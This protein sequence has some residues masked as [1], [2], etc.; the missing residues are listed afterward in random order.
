MLSHLRFHRR[1][2][3]NPTSP[4]RE[5]AP[6][7]EAAAQREQPQPARDVSPRPDARPRSPNSSQLPPT[8]PPIVRVAST[9]SDLLFSP[10]HDTP[11]LPPSHDARQPPSRPAYDDGNKGGFI[12]GVALRNYRRAAQDPRPPDTGT[13]AM[14]VQLPENQLSRAKAPP[15]PIITGLTAR[16]A[17]PGN[18]QTKSSWFSTPTDLQGPGA[19]GKR[20]TAPRLASEPTPGPPPEP[21][22]GRKGLPF[23]KNPMSSLLMR[24]KTGQTVVEAHPPALSY[25]PRIK[26]TRVHDFS[27]PRPK[28]TLSL[29]SPD[30]VSAPRQETV[31]PVVRPADHGDPAAPP[32]AGETTEYSPVETARD[33]LYGAGQGENGDTQLE[34]EPTRLSSGTILPDQPMSPEPPNDEAATSLHTSSSAASRDT[35]IAPLP[36]TASASVRTTASR[37]LSV[38]EASR[39]DSVAS[40]IPRHMKSTSSRFSFD[41]IGAAKQEKLLEERHRQREQEKKSSDDPAEADA[42]FNDFDDDFDYDAMMDDDGLEERIPGVNAD[43]EYEEYEEDQEADFDPD[44]DQENF[45]G[46]EFQRSEPASSLASPHTPGMLAT[47]RDTAGKVIEAAQMAAASGKFRRSSS[48]EGLAG[49]ADAPPADLAQDDDAEINRYLDD[50]GNDNAEINGYLDDYGNDDAEINGYLDD[51]GNDDFGNDFDDF[52]FDDEAIIAEANA[53]ALAYDSDGFYGQEFGFY[54]SAPAPQHP[55]NNH[56]HQ[57]PTTQPSA[58]VLTTENLFQYANGGYF[59][60]ASAGIDRSA[61]GRVCR[62]PNLTPITERSEYSN[63]NSVMSFTLPPAIGDNGGRNSASLTSPGLA[64]LALLPDDTDSMSLSALMKL[65]SKAWGGSQASLVSSREGSPRSERAAGP[66]GVPPPPLDGGGSPYGTVPAHLAGH[67]RVNSGL[68][69]WSSFSADEAAAE[70]G[71]SGAASPAAAMAMPPRPGSAGAVVNGGSAG[72]N[73]VVVSPLPQ[74]PHSLFLPPLPPPLPVPSP[75]GGQQQQMGGSACSPVLEG[76]EADPEAAAVV[77]GFALAPALPLR[78]RSSIEVVPGEVAEGGAVPQARRLGGGHRHKGSADSISYMKDGGGN[79]WNSFGVPSF[80]STRC[81]GCDHP[82]PRYTGGYGSVRSNLGTLL[83]NAKYI[84]CDVCA[85][86]SEGILKFL[87]DKSCGVTREDVDELRVDFNLASSR[88][89]LEA[90]LLLDTP[91]KL[92]FFASESTPWISETLPDLPG[93]NESHTACNSFPAAPLPSRVLDVAAPGESGV[94]LY[95]SEGETAPYTA[96]S[97]CW[98]HKP[99]LRTLSGSLDDHKS[100]I[101]WARLPLSFQDAI[102]FTRQLGIRYLWID[103]LC[104]IQDD[105]HD[106]CHEAAKMG[107]VYQNADLVISAAK[108]SGAY[109]GMYAELP[110]K[111][112]IHTIQYTPGRDDDGD[113]DDDFS[114]SE[115]EEVNTTADK[116]NKPPPE[117]IHIRL[118]LS[119]THRLLSPYHAPTSSLPIFTRGWI[120]QERLLSPRILHFGPEELSFECFESSTCQC[121]LCWRRLVE[122]YSRLRLT[123]G[124]DVFPAVS[125]MARQMQSVRG[126]GTRYVAGLWED[127][128]VWGDLLWHVQLPPSSSSPSTEGETLVAGAGLDGDGAAAR[129]WG[130]KEVCR[131]AGWRAP[132]WSWASVCAPVEFVNGDEGL[133]PECE[134]VE[135]ACEPAG[136]DLLGELVEGGSWLVLK[137]RLVPALLRFND[138]EEPEPWN[139][140]DLD[141]LDGGH[142]KNLWVDDD[143]QGLVATEG[144]QPRVYCLLVG[145]KLPRKELLFLVLA[146][147]PEDEEKAPRDQGPHEDRHLYRRIGMMEIFGGPASP[148]F[149]GWVHNLLGKGEDAVVK[150]V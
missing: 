81:R 80:G 35:Q 43:Y 55:P 130:A 139:L 1:A 85:I 66:A 78:A 114:S 118:S 94:R 140:V 150:I 104:I 26:G 91:I 107:S 119:H 24:R 42:R 148:V 69:L 76:E 128:L 29:S 21:Q 34:R 17:V 123:Q 67:V 44:N 58:G 41:M 54:S 111:H 132:S 61:S 99:F 84:G 101:A 53:S 87:S 90:T 6:A 83:S 122:D 48:P 126:V 4:L 12:G 49:L 60:P 147:V 103:S 59:G 52:D 28:K 106:W 124:K 13:A 74:R 71:G 33:T 116:N 105:Q 120:L 23:L 32:F 27:A 113:D 10:H 11:L 16:P 97:H 109:G 9:G 141:V 134:V 95:V 50:Y 102:T 30:A 37:Q 40:A 127:S 39:R 143:C 142:L 110:D 93:G 15:P 138:V 2:P 115:Q 86:L 20:P 31:S 73:G 8:L 3:S 96:L 46:F 92:C 7:W 79:M 38:S 47:P 64:Q 136:V 133:Q 125:G 22:K 112:K 89:S 131:P 108:A 144:G 36:P 129:R 75:G 62:E 57:P 14:A 82:R 65:R 25:D 146:R 68:S 70:A 18:K 145:R 5:Q 135:V 137:G 56:A 149:W 63:R 121:T 88:R 19:P 77:D 51:Y 117:T 98:G 45:A 100:E 72:V